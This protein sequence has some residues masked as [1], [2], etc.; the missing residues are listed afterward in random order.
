MAAMVSSADMVRLKA[1]SPY[2]RDESGT[3]SPASAGPAAAEAKS[4]A[5]SSTHTSVFDRNL[6]GDVG[7]AVVGVF[8]TVPQIELARRHRHAE[9]ELQRAR[10]PDVLRV[11]KGL[12]HR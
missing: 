4:C 5:A 12:L 10:Q 11:R 6:R 1:D 8:E 7:A 3:G 9:G 2:R